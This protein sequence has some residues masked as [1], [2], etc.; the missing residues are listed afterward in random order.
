[1]EE[2]NLYHLL[3]YY[4]T[5]WRII[6]VATLIGLAVGLIYTSI[7]QTPVYKSEATLLLVNPNANQAPQDQIL[8]NN[9]VELF[10]SRRVLLP[11]IKKQ[12]ID[13]DYREVESIVMATAEKDTD[14]IK[15]S[16]STTDP[17]QSQ[18]FINAAIASFKN[19]AK[20]LYGAANS[21]TLCSL[22]NH[23]SGSAQQKI[24]HYLSD[25]P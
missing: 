13:M 21:S 9:Y 19:Q 25:Q 4:A 18:D 7:I 6:L 20:Q 23:Q 5:K 16:I 15:V 8:I 14:V 11:A 3:K 1:M 2:I 10:E 24:D 12:G 22:T 17:K